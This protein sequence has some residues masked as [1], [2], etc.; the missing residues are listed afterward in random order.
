V[1][2]CY[3]RKYVVA[4]D[5]VT[6]FTANFQSRSHDALLRVCCRV[7]NSVLTK[8]GEYLKKMFF[9]DYKVTIERVQCS[10]SGSL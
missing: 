4:M 2:L 3:L 5:V 10:P 9:N 7:G 6:D 1:V 8:I